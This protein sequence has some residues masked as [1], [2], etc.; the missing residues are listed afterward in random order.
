MNTNQWDEEGCRRTTNS[1]EGR[2]TVCSAF[3]I[4]KKLL[5]DGTIRILWNIDELV[6]HYTVSQTRMQHSSF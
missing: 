1:W 6:P 3:S 2:E 5:D 4:T